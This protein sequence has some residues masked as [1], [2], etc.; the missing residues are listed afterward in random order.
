M[1]KILVSTRTSSAPMRNGNG[2]QGC[3]SVLPSDRALVTFTTE[4]THFFIFTSQPSP[5]QLFQPSRLTQRSICCTKM[6]SISNDLQ[7]WVKVAQKD[8]ALKELNGGGT[9]RFDPNFTDAVIKAT[10]PKA[11]PRFAQI[12]PGLTRHLHDFCR[13]CEVTSDEFMAALDLGSLLHIL[14]I[15]FRI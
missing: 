9:N 3:V 6:A 7:Q 14:H 8:R 11:N 13:E 15:V 4:E 1:E 12:M 10:G 5:P 2:L